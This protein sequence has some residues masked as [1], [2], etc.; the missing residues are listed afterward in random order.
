MDVTIREFKNVDLVEVTGRVD[1]STAPK[2]DQV[3]KGLVDKGRSR[4]VLDLK[5][6]DYLSS[7]G[8]RAM[9]S[10]L[11]EV[12]KPIFGGDLR[13]AQPSQ[14]VM[15]VLE[16]AGLDAVLKIYDDQVGAVGSF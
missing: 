12:Q 1:S 13:I 16:L 8:L 9:I 7:A 4:I 15:E 10:C 5:D 2:L 6:V 14:R 3:L 11:R